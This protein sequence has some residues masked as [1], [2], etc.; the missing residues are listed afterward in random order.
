MHERGIDWQRKALFYCQDISEMTALMYYIQLSLI[1]AAA[2]VIVGD[3]LKIE[4]RLALITPCLMVDD[5]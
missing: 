5:V 2:V 4:S 3:T 1:G